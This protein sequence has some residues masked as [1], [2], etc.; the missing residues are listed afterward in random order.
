MSASDY[1]VWVTTDGGARLALLSQFTGLTATRT[2]NGTGQF[3]LTIPVALFN[4]N[5]LGVDKMIQVW[6][7]PSG[8]RLS[9]FR[10]YFLRRWRYFYKDA[11]E[12]LLLSGPD[13]NDLLRRRIVA[14]YAG[15]AQAQK[16]DYAD[17]MMKDVVREA[18]LDTAAPT[19]TAGTRAWPNLT[20][21]AD[22]SLGPTITK[23]FAFSTLLTTSGG[24]VLPGLADAAEVAGTR[25]YFDISE[26]VLS[27]TTATWIFNTYIGQP[28]ADRTATGF[29]FDLN[30]GN[31]RDPA[32]EYDYSQEQNYIYAAGRGEGVERTIQ[33]VYDAGRY[34]ASIWNRCE[35]LEDARDQEF[36]DGVRERG[37]AA[38]YEGRPRT[39]F[40]AVP[41]DV[42]GARF[43]VD[44]T[45]GDRV[46]AQYRNQLFECVI[47]SVGVTVTADGE[48][49]A[50][51]LEY[52]G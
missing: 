50:A 6:R 5:L 46:E 43:G 17:D 33:Q 25:V 11:D 24:G 15:N 51:R 45:F 12:Y 18:I 28:G 20:I 52:E 39:R 9:L 21:A 7:A 42:N 4:T 16:T 13:V 38:L 41:L 3:S 2:V 34:G 8:G 37:R 27:G 29:T 22:V 19:P 40:S 14:S 35:A 23:G 30:R 31:M 10:A 26:N 1:E 44:W 48:R 36:D 47:E 32:L 49:I